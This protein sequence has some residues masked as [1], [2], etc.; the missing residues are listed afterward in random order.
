[1][2]NRWSPE[3]RHSRRMKVLGGRMVKDR[4]DMIGDW[5]V[6]TPPQEAHRRVSQQT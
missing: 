5:V 1:V 3:L 2:R 6:Y 4:Q